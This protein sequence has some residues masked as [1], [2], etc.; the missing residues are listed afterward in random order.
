MFKFFMLDVNLF[1]KKNVSK[2]KCMKKN[3]D[4]I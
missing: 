3:M 4:I 1:V 2:N